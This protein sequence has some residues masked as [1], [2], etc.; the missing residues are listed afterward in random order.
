MLLTTDVPTLFS[1]GQEAIAPIIA[2]V[3]GVVTAL[4]AAQLY[5][6]NKTKGN[7]ELRAPN[8]QEMWV[9]QELD[10]RARQVMEDMWWDLRSAFKS[11]FRRVTSLLLQL[12][13]DDKRFNLTTS[14]KKAIDATP[15]ED[16]GPVDAGK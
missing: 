5:R 10:R 12:N 8:V 6:R 14:E 15:P 7:R 1:W 3:F 13:I 4:V 11:Y 2:G 16:P 9:Q